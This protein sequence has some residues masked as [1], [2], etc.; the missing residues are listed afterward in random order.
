MALL[1]SSRPVKKLLPRLLSGCLNSQPSA[2]DLELTNRCNLSCSMCWFHGKQGIGDRYRDFELTNEEVAHLA[3]QLSPF[4]TKVY[5]GGG[6]VM[7]RKD[8]LAV[9]AH[10]K[11]YGLPVAFATNGTLMNHKTAEKLVKM[12]VDQINFSIDGPEA[13][14]DSIRGQGVFSKATDAIRCLSREKEK[15]NHCQPNG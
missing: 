12:E 14:H 11:K 2:V 7:L 4:K 9:L 6:E 3:Q 15:N 1:E 8:F 10:L 13:Q 5:L